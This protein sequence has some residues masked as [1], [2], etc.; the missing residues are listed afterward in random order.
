MGNSRRN[1]DRCAQSG[2]VQER[3]ADYCKPTLEWIYDIPCTQE[4][5]DAHLKRIRAQIGTQYNTLDILG[6]LFR[7]RKLTSPGRVI[8][9]QFVSAEALILWWDRYL[10]LLHGWEFLVT[11]EASH[12]SPILIGHRRK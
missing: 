7:N 9:S 5:Q 3:A 10:N 1:V 6:I 8:C 11:P 4:V 12:L 2:G